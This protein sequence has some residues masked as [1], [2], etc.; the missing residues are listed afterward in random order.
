MI[1]TALRIVAVIVAV[2]ITAIAGAETPVP[3]PAA[4]AVNGSAHSEPATAAT[5]APNDS[6]VLN[7]EGADIR[8]VI[9][10]LADS[11][12]INYQIDPRIQGQ[13]TIRTTG[14]I[15]KE[16]LFPIFNR[17]LRANGISAVQVGDIYQI[18]PVAEAK[19]KAIIPVAPGERRQ[20]AREDA[21]VIEVVKVEHVAAQE[22]V[23]VLQPFVTPG[24]DVIPYARA[25][26][27][28][29]TDLES[30]VARL[31]DLVATFDRDAFRDLRAKVY[32]IEHANIEEIGQELI[33]IMDT[34]GVTPAS[35]EERGV[36]VIPLQR[37]NSL[38]I[39]AFNPT[40]FAE[41]DRW[42]KLLDVPPEEGAGRSVHVYAVENAKAADLA[43]ILS[44]LYGEGSSSRQG[45]QQGFTPFG[46]RTRGGVGQQ[47]GRAGQPVVGRQGAPQIAAPAPPRVNQMLDDFDDY[48]P[49]Q[50]FDDTGG[51]GIGSATSSRRSSGRSGGLGGSS[52][53]GG[54]GNTRNTS[55]TFGGTQGAQGFV[56]AGGEPGD[57]FR[58]EVRIVADDVTN[59]LVVLATK[60][61]YADIREV[62]RRLD[63]VPR[64]VLIEVLVAEVT[65]GDDMKFGVEWAMADQSRK[66]A[67]GRITGE[68][69]NTNADSK[70]TSP[71][72]NL[73]DL[74]AAL[75]NR[76]T[77]VVPLPG[78]GMFGIISDNRNFAVVMNAAAGKNKLKVLSAPHIMTA[79]NHEAHI[80]V[81]NEVPIVTTQSN[82]N[83]TL[84]AGTSNILQNIQYRDTGVILTVLPQVNS[85]GL[86]NMQIRQE[87]SQV[88][89]AT[90]GGIQSPTFS[91][92]E[93]ETTVVVQSGETIVIGGIIDDSVD[94]SRTGVPFL[95]DIP[96]VGRAFRI[97][98][99]TVRRTELI[100]LLTPHVV[101]DRQESRYATE[102]F[103]SR[104]KGMERDLERYDRDRPDYGSGRPSPATL[105]ELRV[106]P[107]AP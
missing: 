97:E 24:G 16:D 51:G 102:A 32:K 23:N 90:T 47:G 5:A 107:P 55:G 104:L 66:G 80:L 41:I 64:Q 20:A 56:L 88:A 12:G 30:N 92:R 11:L 98:S 91:T 10:S 44:Q 59:S 72:P 101:R 39:V 25:N 79:D 34:Y 78:S 76:S 75:G 35:A 61:D 29:V 81:G 22:M 49:L 95:M 6:V 17:I 31:K 9:H 45:Q 21:F 18:I 71:S 94:R 100:V 7:F 27:L 74:G 84:T 53:R 38:V 26:L 85:E 62:L 15:A 3:T 73:F 1:R 48:A 105:D 43:E 99:D 4:T 82:A 87:V 36:Y 70:S 77:D 65:L 8:E 19:T 93:S 54:F 50:Q 60:K 69:T 33:A 103:K 86:V 14:P 37:L 2:G 89:S 68:P 28:I 13:V 67:L 57:I 42:M 52:S 46:T 83:Y 96:V 58:Q 40:I 63:V 106:S